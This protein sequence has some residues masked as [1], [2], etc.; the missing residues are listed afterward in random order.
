M[1]Q[2]GG[3][4]CAHDMMWRWSDMLQCGGVLCT[5]DMIWSRGYME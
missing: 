4:L 5:H 2:C 1:L 3:V